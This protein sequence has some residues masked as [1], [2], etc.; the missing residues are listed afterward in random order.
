MVSDDFLSQIVE[1]ADPQQHSVR[2]RTSRRD[3]KTNKDELGL[4]E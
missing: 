1:H 4:M 3:K 2:D